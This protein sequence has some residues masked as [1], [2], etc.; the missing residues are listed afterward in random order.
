MSSTDEWPLG[1]PDIGTNELNTRVDAE[2]TNPQEGLEKTD[3]DTELGLEITEDPQRVSR[4]EL[5]DDEAATE[6]VRGDA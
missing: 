2:L 1:I 5:S 6:V 4:G 3:D